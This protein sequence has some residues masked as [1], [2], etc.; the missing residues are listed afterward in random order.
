M[1]QLDP[2]GRDAQALSSSLTSC[3]FAPWFLVCKLVIRA[4]PTSE[5]VVRT[6]SDDAS[7]EFSPGPGTW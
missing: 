3:H 5:L 6:G 1:F 2:T 4:I 7:E